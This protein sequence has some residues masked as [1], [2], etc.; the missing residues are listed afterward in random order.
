M[1]Y[2]P[3]LAGGAVLAYAARQRRPHGYRS[4]QHETQIALMGYL[5]QVA[6]RLGVGRHVYV[7]GGAVRNFLIDRPIKDIDVV[8]DSVALRGKD[9]D[10]FALRLAE[11]I[12]ARTNVITNQ[13]GVAILT[14]KGDWYVGPYNLK[15]EVIEIANARKESYGGVGGKGYKPDQV[16]PATIEEDALRREFTFNT[17]L[18]RLSDLAQGPEKAEIIDLT[19]CGVA[20]LRRRQI[21]CPRSP[22]IVFSD[23]PTRMLRAIKFSTKYGFTIPPDVARSIRRNASKLKNVPWEAVG[24]IFVTNVLKE[25]TAPQALRQMKDLGLLDT[26]GQMVQ[27][28]PSFRAYLSKQLRTQNVKV[29]FALLD[30]GMTD[31]TPLD[32]LTPTQ[33]KKLQT[34]TARLSADDADHFAA[35]V[36]KPPLNNRVIIDRYNLKGADRRRP[37]MVA[38]V[39]LLSHPPT[40]W[41]REQLTQRV[42]ERMARGQAGK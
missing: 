23:D 29:L 36:A 38:R 10:W 22:D 15:G 26:V 32:Y 25:P 42:M 17:L 31:P 1:N 30:L 7:V 18:W 40:Q 39:V 37:A 35:L 3:W 20:D 28:R 21:V 6:R 16:V 12:P 9:S 19:G 27:E 2:L 41:T 13:Y 8:V 14:V 24:N 33:R 5:S 4:A 34:L 11:A